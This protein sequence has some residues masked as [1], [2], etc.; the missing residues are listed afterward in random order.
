M[1]AARYLC[2]RSSETVRVTTSPRYS[3]IM[4]SCFRAF[5]ANRP[6]PW[7]PDC[8]HHTVVIVLHC[9]MG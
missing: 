1:P 6:Q 5:L 4:L 7:M 9:Y 3:M 2:S 8:T